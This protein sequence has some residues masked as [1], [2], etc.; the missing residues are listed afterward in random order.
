M[1]TLW[2]ATLAVLCGSA[3]A[4]PLVFPGTFYETFAGGEAVAID[5]NDS[6]LARGLHSGNAT[7]ITVGGGHV[8]WQDGVNIW[9]ANLDLGGAAIWHVNG[10][11]PADIAIDAAAGALY[12]SFAGSEIVAISLADSSR[13]L[14]IRLGNATNI[15]AG[16]GKVYWQDGTRI[17]RANSD[18]SGAALFHTNGIASTDIEL[19]LESGALLESFAGSEIVAISL[20]NPSLA[21]GFHF[22]N[23]TNLT[24]GDGRLYWQ[25]GVN[26]YSANYDFSDVSLWHING[27]ASTDIAFQGDIFAPP[28]ETPEPSSLALTAAGLLA[29]AG[30][31][32]R[33]AG[34]RLFRKVMGL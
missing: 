5:K 17:Y 8:Y 10:A 28:P 20:A 4:A 26:I 33:R 30:R 2:M 34:R 9:R 14:G 15:T 7:N 18:L 29:V 27:I 22:G 12:E 6:R 16:G 21:L 13:A 24:H 31:R 23:A 1:K 25:D 11:A 3:G 19:V 32:R